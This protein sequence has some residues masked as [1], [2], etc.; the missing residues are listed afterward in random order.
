MD[1]NMQ[2]HKETDFEFF[3]IVQNPYLIHT[4]HGV[5][6]VTETLNADF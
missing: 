1:E 2:M 5:A 6:S 4:T 3:R